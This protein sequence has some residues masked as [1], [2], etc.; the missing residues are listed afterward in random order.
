MSEFDAM[1]VQLNAVESKDE[2]V[3]MM[4]ELYPKAI[5]ANQGF[6]LTIGGYDDDPRELYEIPEVIEFFKLLVE[7]GFLSTLTVSTHLELEGE[8]PDRLGIGALEVWLMA[9]GHLT[10]GIREIDFT[11]FENF[12]S[13]LNE[14]N[15]VCHN[16][17][18]PFLF[19][20]API[21]EGQSRVERP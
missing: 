19:N 12:M 16:N 3:Q 20:Y 14:S 13:F 8:T 2:L 9:N 1:I 10:K 4:V 15:I 11:K 21:K 17:I 7:I 6:H 5:E 18:A